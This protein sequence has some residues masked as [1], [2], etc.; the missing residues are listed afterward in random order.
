MLLNEKYQVETNST[1]LFLYRLRA[2]QTEEQL[3]ILSIARLI[4][5]VGEQRV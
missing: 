4:F 1:I 2:T 3:S 5:F